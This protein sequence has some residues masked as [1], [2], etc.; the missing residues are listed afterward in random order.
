MVPDHSLYFLIFK[1]AFFLI[2]ILIEIWALR[3]CARWF[4]AKRFGYGWIIIGIF[5]SV[6]FSF[7]LSL[8]NITL[9]LTHPISSHFL[10]ITANIFLMVFTLALMYWGILGLNG[11]KQS[12]KFTLVF[13]VLTLVS[14]FAFLIIL[15]VITSIGLYI[16]KKIDPEKVKIFE[17]QIQAIRNSEFSN[18]P[19]LVI[20]DPVA[21]FSQTAYKL[22]QCAPDDK[23]CREESGKAMGAGLYT[24][25]R[26]MQNN[27]NAYSTEQL[28]QAESFIKQASYCWKQQ[29]QRL[30]ENGASQTGAPPVATTQTNTAVIVAPPT[31]PLPQ[32]ATTP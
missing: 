17:N 22:C 28:Q 9:W 1:Y 31:E 6:L 2:S 25:K 5:A 10:L 3:K 15:G 30:K 11:F 18:H 19:T 21:Y 14:I 24:M 12:I 20:A 29:E 13:L 4:D 16:F 27:Q 23:V 26:T 8:L 32:T 7:A